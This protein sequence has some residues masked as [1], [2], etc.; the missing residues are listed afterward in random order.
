MTGATHYT[1]CG[2]L[3]DL[4]KRRDAGGDVVRQSLYERRITLCEVA[5]VK[6]RHEI[7]HADGREHLSFA[8]DRHGDR[9]GRAR[10]DHGVA[11]GIALLAYNS[12]Q[13]LRSSAIDRKPVFGISRS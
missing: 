12:K 9:P 10:L 6:R 8:D 1:S 4:P 3:R 2:L 5:S 7:G 11:L 13:R